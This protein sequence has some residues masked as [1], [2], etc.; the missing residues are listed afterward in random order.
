M[1]VTACTFAVYLDAA[2]TGTPGALTTG[3][4]RDTMQVSNNTANPTT[5]QQMKVGTTGAAL[6]VNVIGS[7]LIA[8]AASAEE[9]D[10]KAL[11]TLLGTK[12]LSKARGLIFRNTADAESGHDVKIEAGTSNGFAPF[13]GGTTPYLIIPPQGVYALFNPQIAA[14]VVDS[15]HSTIKFDPGANTVNIE[16]GVIGE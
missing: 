5:G 10:L 4:P 1:G 3:T 9:V 6:S 15:T 16:F 2:E 13:L 12:A 11:V 14:W 7:Q 8:L